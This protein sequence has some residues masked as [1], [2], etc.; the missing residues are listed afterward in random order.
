MTSGWVRY[1]R[2]RTCD[3]SRRKRFLASLLGPF[4]LGQ[5]NRASLV[6]VPFRCA[7][8]D[9]GHIPARGTFL[10]LVGSDEG[11]LAAYADL[12]R[13]KDGGI[14][15]HQPT[16]SREGRARQKIEK[17]MEEGG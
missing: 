9:Q 14:T 7:S 10:F 2:N 3:R 15:V 8:R 13:P 6:A 5:I 17:G 1:S 11:L 16:V 4:T 12:V